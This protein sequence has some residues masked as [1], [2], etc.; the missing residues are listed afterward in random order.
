MRYRGLET[1]E[2]GSTNNG[3]SLVCVIQEKII[4]L[5][6]M[7]KKMSLACLPLLALPSDSLA[8]A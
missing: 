5:A 4:S 6:G 3:L 1:L 8:T 7:I 2:L